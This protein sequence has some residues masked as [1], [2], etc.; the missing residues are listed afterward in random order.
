M[1]K[2]PKF[3]KNPSAITYSSLDSEG[4]FAIKKTAENI[5]VTSIPTLTMIILFLFNYSL[6][7]SGLCLHSIKGRTRAT[8]TY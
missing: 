6:T 3:H 1:I 5:K 8:C 4:K 2:T 7:T